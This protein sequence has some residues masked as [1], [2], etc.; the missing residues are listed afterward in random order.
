MFLDIEGKALNTCL[1]FLHL[2]LQIIAGYWAVKIDG[3]SC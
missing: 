1:R 3:Y 2:G